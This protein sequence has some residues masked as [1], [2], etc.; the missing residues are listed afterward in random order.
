MMPLV[1]CVRLSG[2][3]CRDGG[4]FYLLVALLLVLVGFAFLVAFS[5]YLECLLHFV[6]LVVDD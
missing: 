3:L 5:L 2:F 6:I 4:L 1:D